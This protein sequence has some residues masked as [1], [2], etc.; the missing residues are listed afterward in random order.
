MRNVEV[1][2]QTTDFFISFFYINFLNE[3]LE[4]AISSNLNLKKNLI[5]VFFKSK[6]VSVCIKKA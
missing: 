3:K 4:E 2:F 1:H 6:K 5:K